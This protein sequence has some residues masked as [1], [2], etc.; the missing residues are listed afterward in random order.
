[1]LK[2]HKMP[3]LLVCIL[4][5]L[6]SIACNDS[7]QVNKKLLEK[8]KYLYIV[9]DEKGLLGLMNEKGEIVLNKQKRKIEKLDI[10]GHYFSIDGNRLFSI[11]DGFVTIKLDSISLEATYD[12]FNAPLFIAQNDKKW[13]LINEKGVVLNSFNVD[14]KLIP[15]RLTNHYLVK[16]GE[17]LKVF[18]LS[19]HKLVLTL[20]SQD[21]VSEHSKYKNLL[22]VEKSGKVEIFN[23]NNPVK[24]YL[25]G[26]SLFSPTSSYFNT[27]WKSGADSLPVIIAGES[28]LKDLETASLKNNLKVLQN[29]NI[30]AFVDTNLKLVSDRK[31]S[32]LDLTKYNPYLKVFSDEKGKKFINLEI[33]KVKKA[34]PVFLTRQTNWAFATLNNNSYIPLFKGN[35]LPELRTED[36]FMIFGP[37]YLMPIIDSKE[38]ISELRDS[39]GK[40]IIPSA[41][42][43]FISISLHNQEKNAENLVG[44]L[45]KDAL[46]IVDIRNSK[47]SFVCNGLEDESLEL[48]LLD[49]NILKIN[50]EALFNLDL[51]KFILGFDTP[52]SFAK[53]VDIGL[54]YKDVLYY[55]RSGFILQNE[56]IIKE[57]VV[58]FINY[59]G[60]AI[61]GADF[62][63]Y[64][65]RK[66]I[67][68]DFEKDMLIA[69]VPISPKKSLG[70]TYY[71]D[72][73]GKQIWPKNELKSSYID[74]INNKAE[75]IERLSKIN[76]ET[77]MILLE[78]FN[79]NP[80][81]ALKEFLNPIIYNKSNPKGRITLLLVYDNDLEEITIDFDD[82]DGL[83]NNV[84]LKKKLGAEQFIITADIDFISSEGR[85]N[86]AQKMRILHIK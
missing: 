25:V 3:K 36:V 64:D 6:M 38:G 11:K 76:A 74:F 12:Y 13:M 32:Y 53:I 29:Q 15:S 40:I 69:L 59:E 72:L 58:E 84:E 49:D 62:K 22:L 17:N 61:F 43:K 20:N 60:K 44:L 71:F 85:D 23:S 51:N 67:N 75:L 28:E 9:E 66:A 70:Q 56:K 37:N 10:K 54:L 55:K 52:N 50:N 7:S 26:S 8:S 19:T 30:F 4:L 35:A 27:Y 34:M 31:Y 73:K 41:K 83:E 46:F 24:S 33:D 1:M 39:S 65:N 57:T 47:T 68:R 45:K 2:I 5:L 81:K 48:Q 21:Q 18:S 86:G 78:K 42:Q 82:I 80:C 14:E 79:A 77:N 16:N 63:F